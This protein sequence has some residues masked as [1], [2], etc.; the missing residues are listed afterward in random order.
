MR[1]REKEQPV[2]LFGLQRKKR[3]HKR[4]LP[5][6]WGEF[7][8]EKT[9]SAPVSLYIWHALTSDIDTEERRMEYDRLQSDKSALIFLSMASTVNVEQNHI[10]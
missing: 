2:I 6:K 3:K 5:R 4:K 8:R 9:V 1:R 10:P 7:V